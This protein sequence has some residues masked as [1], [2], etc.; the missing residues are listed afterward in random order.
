MRD[1]S[2]DEFLAGS[3]EGDEDSGSE[4]DDEGRQG[5]ATDEETATD[6]GADPDAGTDAERDPDPGADGG[7]E[8]GGEP[9]AETVE[10]A[11]STFAWSPDGT[12]CAECGEPVEERWAGESGL[13]C[14]ECKSW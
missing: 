3:G 8:P 1:A 11:R 13:V 6:E 12:R 2:L 14:G 5:A 7:A 9:P 10:P 4:A